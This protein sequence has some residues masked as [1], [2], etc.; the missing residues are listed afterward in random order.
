MPARST[1][2]SR[3]LALLLV[4]AVGLFVGA[5]SSEARADDIPVGPVVVL[6][7]GGGSFLLGG[8]FALLSV[9]AYDTAETAVTQTDAISARD[10]GSTFA[11]AGNFAFLL[12]GV[13][14]LIGLGW[15]SV[16]LVRGDSSDVALRIGP[17]SLALDGT[18]D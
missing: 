11:T 2:S 7:V 3:A 17:G 10:R 12:G 4:L 18:F 14:T 13:F 15:G 16:E 1:R 9:S 5:P 8:L 6:G